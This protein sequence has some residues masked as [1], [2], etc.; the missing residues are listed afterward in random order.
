MISSSHSKNVITAELE[1]GILSHTA[2]HHRISVRPKNRRP[3]KP[4]R[5]TSQSSH[6]GGT[7]ITTISESLDDSGA[8]MD[9]L[10][11]SLNN[12][13]ASSPSTGPTNV[14]R[15]KS[16]SRLSRNSDISDDADG[17]KK[18]VCSIASL[19]PDS[20]DEDRPRRSSNVSDKAPSVTS[21]L[22]SLDSPPSGTWFSTPKSSTPQ[23][24]A[25]P[26][27]PED[28]DEGKEADTLPVARRRKLLLLPAASAMSKSSNSLETLEGRDSDGESS[29]CNR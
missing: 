2:A 12:S 7:S 20:L 22:D 11:I 16:S 17:K 14:V 28:E 27:D 15:R 3:P 29:E 8:T 9:S 10:E 1:S 18:S 4:K 26:K 21:V 25:E 5:A 13:A 23:A 6:V 19:S 24:E